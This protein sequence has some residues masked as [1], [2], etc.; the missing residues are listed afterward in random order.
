V[1]VLIT[2]NRQEK[3]K[4]NKPRVWVVIGGEELPT[5]L[6]IARTA[7]GALY[8]YQSRTGDTSQLT[9]VEE[10]KFDK[11]GLYKLTDLR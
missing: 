11:H 6:V 7:A 9:Y 1:V 3:M 5:A 2:R 4:K 8:T 10:A